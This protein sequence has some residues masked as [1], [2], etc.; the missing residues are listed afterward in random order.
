MIV[1]KNY[2]PC[3]WYE[4][5]ESF[6][7][8]YKTDWDTPIGK[9]T[10]LLDHSD[11]NLYL[12][13]FFGY[14]VFKHWNIKDFICKDILDRIKNKELYLLLNCPGH[15]PHHLV[16]EIYEDVIIKLNLDPK[17]VIISSESLDLNEAVKFVA[18]SLNMENCISQV[19][20]DFHQACTSQAV[21][22][23][24]KEN[25][26]TFTPKIYEKKFL[27]F[28]GHNREHRTALVYG[29][30]SLN[31]IDKGFVS[32]NSKIPDENPELTYWHIIE[33]CKDTNLLQL[34]ESNKHKLSTLAQLKLDDLNDKNL[35][36]FMPEHGYYQNQ[37]YFS[38]ITETN[39][40]TF[41]HLNTVQKSPIETIGRIY[42]EKTFRAILY[43]HPFIILAPKHFLRGLRR[44][45][46]K[47]FSSVIDESY[48]EEENY[49]T[50]IYKVLKEIER[51]CNL[52]NN[53]IKHFLKETEEICQYNFNILINTRNFKEI[54]IS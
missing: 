28:N 53:E 11:K 26:F 32:F 31:L 23:E 34:Y 36:G 51:L 6:R 49:S 13:D 27:S 48:D 21:L 25:Y 29:L 46:Y 50:R 16:K 43:Q 30:S 7:L 24:Q 22:N 54:L 20:Y 9:S 33:T 15:G 38:I 12:I 37:T 5:P 4:H 45:G 2:Y 44:M 40:D 35:A 19:V 41:E 14:G 18:K 8:W 1:N 17:Q 39:Y 47:T 10:S 52:N 3:L 42:S